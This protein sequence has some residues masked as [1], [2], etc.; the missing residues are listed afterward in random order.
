ME[1]NRARPRQFSVPVFVKDL[2][3]LG[4]AEGIAL[5]RLGRG[6]EIENP[7]SEVRIKPERL[8]G[9]D[10][11][12]ASERHGEPRNACVGVGPGGEV[13]GQ[14]GKIGGRTRQPR[15][16]RGPGCHDA[17]R[18]LDP[19]RHAGGRHTARSG[20]VMVRT[21][22]AGAAVAV[23]DRQFVRARLDRLF[24]DFDD[25]PD[26]ATF[27]W[28]NRQCD[29]RPSRIEDGFG[30]DADPAAQQ[31]AIGA[32]VVETDPAI[33]VPRGKEFAA[34]ERNRPA[35][36]ED[37]AKIRPAF[38]NDIQIGLGDPVIR[39]CDLVVEAIGKEA[40]T[41]DV[42][43]EVV[44]F[45]AQTVGQAR[46]CEF[47]LEHH[48]VRTGVVAHRCQ[49]CPV[50]RNAQTREVPCVAKIKTVLGTRL[51]DAG[52][53]RVDVAACRKHREQIAILENMEIVPGVRSEPVGDDLALRRREN[54]AHSACR[55]VT[56]VH[57]EWS[58][59]PP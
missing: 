18:A 52:S 59:G 14:D 38:E 37:V 36:F 17:R 34:F 28:W 43:L 19:L 45:R 42:Q 50:D 44:E 54:G 26:F 23:G 27:F 24:R 8:H 46:I 40:V 32:G 47:A 56:L 21:R 5:G 6:K 33:S 35:H 16:E 1:G 20:E 30:F 15:I 10:Q 25:A 55:F 3:R 12:V 57:G 29:M 7:A 41:P 9:R 48:A 31:P 51:A 53:W 49:A 11:T 39:E 2:A 22:R 4:I 13:G 58:G